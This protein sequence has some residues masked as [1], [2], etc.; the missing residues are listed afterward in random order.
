MSIELIVLI[1]LAA[2]VLY[3]FFLYNDLVTARVRVDQSLKDIDVQLKK[4]YDLLPDLV[5]T[6]RKATNLDEKVFT[7]VARL[8]SQA[9]EAQNSGANVA[10]RSQLENQLSSMMRDIKVSVEAYPDIKSHGELSSLM[11]SVT[12][13]EEK[14]AYARQFYN[15]NAADYNTKIKLFPA[16]VLAS[17]LGFKEAEY[18]AA[19]EEEKADVKVQ[20]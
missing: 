7:E 8:R 11:E 16:V 9:I 1:I 6:A 10:S 17:S 5:E 4:R 19:P 12:G 18:F 2:A 15:S 20:F 14:I 3:V 13:I